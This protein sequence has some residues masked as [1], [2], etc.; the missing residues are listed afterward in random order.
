MRSRIVVASACLLVLLMGVEARGAEPVELSKL[1]PQEAELFVE[2][3]GLSRL[4]LP[5]EILAA[6]MRGIM[7]G[8]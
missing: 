6:T 2:G 1:F 5:P 3:D 7:E 8:K 4:V